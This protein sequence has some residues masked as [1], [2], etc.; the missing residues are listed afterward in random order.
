MP[1]ATT[2]FDQLRQS[3]A[4]LHHRLDLGGGRAAAIWSNDIDRVA[5]EN[6]RLHTLSLYLEHGEESRRLDRGAV[7]GRPGALCLMPQG[8]SSDWAIGGDFRFIHLYLP[9]ERL[10]HLAATALDREPAGVDLPDRTFFDDPAL[11]GAMTALARACAAGDALAA[12]TALAAT[13]HALLT[14]AATGGRPAR[15][16]RGGLA[17]AVSRR[18]IAR[19]REAPE[20]PAGLEELADLAGLSAF[21]FHRMFRHSHGLGPLAYQEN[22]RVETAKRLM[23]AG[24]GLAEVAAAC[25]WCHQ[26]HFTRAFRAATGTT[27]GRWR[28]A[29]AAPSAHRRAADLP[30]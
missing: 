27:P 17:P 4:R 8:S 30:A 7:R 18:V 24:L 2:I 26:S 14:S 10:R 5:Y 9:D 21:H 3:R 19:M 23:R 20:R 16:I 1:A 11:A 29:V 13:C 22:L 6:T 12:E 28:D 15:P 25:G